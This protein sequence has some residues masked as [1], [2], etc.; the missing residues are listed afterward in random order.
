MITD[1]N[2]AQEL[3]RIADENARGLMAGYIFSYHLGVSELRRK[4]D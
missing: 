2:E 4:I 1:V 3:V